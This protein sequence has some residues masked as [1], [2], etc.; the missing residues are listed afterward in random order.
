[1]TTQTGGR[2]GREGEWGEERLSFIDHDRQRYAAKVRLPN[3]GEILV[4]DYLEGGG[5]ERLG[6]F[7]IVL[8][9]LG[10]RG[11]LLH[12]QLCVFGDGAVALAALLG[13]DG[14]DLAALLAPVAGHE[15][16][17]R[18]LLALG[19]SDLSDTPL[20]AGTEAG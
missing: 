10:H 2:T 9:D 8:H 6:E 3:E 19:L 12:P 15:D 5:T 13:L 14:T 7:R 18:C 11:G 4:G 16:L 1:M 20:D 17:C